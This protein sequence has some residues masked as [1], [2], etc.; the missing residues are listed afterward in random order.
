M[1]GKFKLLELIAFHSNS[2]SL[3]LDREKGVDIKTELHFQ[4]QE[5]GHLS[6]FIWSMI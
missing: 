3:L 2:T 4:Y 5:R 1:G 6:F